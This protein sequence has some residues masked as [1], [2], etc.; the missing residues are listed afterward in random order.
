MKVTYMFQIARF[1]KND[2]EKKK[3]S[4][5]TSEQTIPKFE[6]LQNWEF[7]GSYMVSEKS[8]FLIY[9]LNSLYNR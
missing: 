6:A 4:K 1:K 3:S 5:L 9:K 7:K 2:Q 8:Y